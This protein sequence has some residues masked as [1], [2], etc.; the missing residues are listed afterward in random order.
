MGS[1]IYNSG[2]GGTPL[3]AGMANGTPLKGSWVAEPNMNSGGNMQPTPGTAFAIPFLVQSEWPPVVGIGISIY[4]QGSSGAVVRLGLYKDN[5]K[6]YPGKLIIDGGTVAVTTAAN[7]S[8]DI[9]ATTLIPGLY[10]KIV[11]PQGAPVTYA[12]LN[13]MNFGSVIPFLA[14][15]LDEA[16]SAGG[17]GVPIGYQTTIDGALPSSFPS[18]ATVINANPQSPSPAFPIVPLGF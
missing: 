7:Q 5:G 17:G 3:Y 15:T 12:Q 16:C 18:G 9:P 11:A 14:G 4:T 8:V 6:Q 10:W 2:N 13:A 1:I